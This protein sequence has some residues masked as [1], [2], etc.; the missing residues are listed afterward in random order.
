MTFKQKQALY[1]DYLR[2]IGVPAARRRQF[3][4]DY[5]GH[6]PMPRHCHDCHQPVTDGGCTTCAV[7][8]VRAHRLCGECT[9]D[10]TE[11][12][13]HADWCSFSDVFAGGPRC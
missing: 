4:L 5:S 12:E 9:A 6:G 1:A 11:G 8:V 10:L 3:A 13:L 2:D 7:P